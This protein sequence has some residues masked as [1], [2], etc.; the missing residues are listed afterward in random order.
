MVVITAQVV[1]S[2]LG[3]DAFQEADMTGITYNPLTQSF[4][5]SDDTDVNY[6]AHFQRNDV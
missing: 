5:L 3:K 1:R 6:L 2:L 4:R